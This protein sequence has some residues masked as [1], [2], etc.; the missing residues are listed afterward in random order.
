MQQNVPS[1]YK[2]M[3][4][5]ISSWTRHGHEGLSLLVVLGETY[6]SA[7]AAF[8]PDIAQSQSNMDFC[9]YM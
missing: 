3:S 4:N 7:L 6:V 5:G 1:H 8:H 9:F 2:G